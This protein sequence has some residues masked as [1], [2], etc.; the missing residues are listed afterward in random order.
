MQRTVRCCR[1]EVIRAHLDHADAWNL[2][3]TYFKQFWIAFCATSGD[4]GRTEADVMTPGGDSCYIMLEVIHK[5]NHLDNEDHC[6]Q[7]SG[8]PD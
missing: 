8:E 4:S 6:S 2:K 3:I 5:F 7:I 1:A